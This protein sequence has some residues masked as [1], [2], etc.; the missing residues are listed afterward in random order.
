MQT[1]APC[2][3]QQIGA[4]LTREMDVPM[5]NQSYR[6]CQPWQ[7][8][9]GYSA[10][11]PPIHLN[12]SPIVVHSA[13]VAPTYCPIRGVPTVPAPLSLDPSQ[14]LSAPPPP[15]SGSGFEWQQHWGAPPLAPPPPCPSLS[16]LPPI[17]NGVVEP[18]ES[19]PDQSGHND[20]RL[21]LGG[22][23]T[24]QDCSVQ[25]PGSRYGLD[26][27]LIPS[28]VTVIE[29]DRAQWEGRVFVSDSSG[30][31]PPL[32]STECTVEDVGSASPRFIRCTS[33]SFPSEGGAAQR[34]HLPLGAIITPLAQPGAG[35]RPLVQVSRSEEGACVLCCGGCA[36]QMCPSFTWQDCGQ[37]FHCPF[38]GHVTEVPW[39]CYQPT[40]RGRTRRVDAEQ[41]AE[42]SHGSY[43]ILETQGQ[44]CPA[45]LLAVDV[46]SQAVRGGQLTHICQQLRSFLD[47]LQRDSGSDQSQLRVGVVTYHS[48]LHLYNLNPALSRPHML[49]ITQTEELELP[50]WEGLLVPLRDC[51][52]AIDKVLQ[53][54]PSLFSEAEDSPAS[55]ELPVH[56]GLHILKVAG[57]PGKVLFFH[58]A[59]P[60]D[61]S[62]NCSSG[63]SG[64]FSSSKEKSLFQPPEHCV[65]LA[66]E[67]VAQGCSFHL[68]LF[69][70]QAVGGAWPGHTP[71][72]TGGGV[73]SYGCLQG[74]VDSE[75]FHSDLRRCVDTET[76][77]RVEM[78]VSVSKGL[79]VSGCFGAFTPGPD[80]AHIRLATIDWHTALAVQFTHHSPLD[81]ERG[82]VIQVALS[83]TSSLGERRT[84][85]H[86]LSLRCSRHLVD[87]FRNCQAETL[88]TFY[89]KRVYCAVLTRPLQDLRD[90]LLT[91]LTAM[92]TCYRQHCSTTALTHGQLVL[93]QGLKSL[94]V[95]LNSLR[96]SEVLLPGL[97]GSVPLRLQLRSQ[98]V[99]MD[100]AS[101]AAHF[102]PQ[103]L[104]LHQCEEAV[105]A[106]RCSRLSL[107]EEGVYLAHDALGLVLW[108]GHHAP[109]SFL[110]CLFNTPSFP[111]L[112]SGECCLPVL[113]NAVSQ[114]VRGLIDTL[115]RR[116]AHSL[117][118][119]VVKQ[120]QGSEEALQRLLVED[121]SPNGGASYPDFLYHVHVSSLKLLP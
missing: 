13:A 108:V 53:Q 35:E 68:F 59:P 34:C 57:C 3:N 11:P 33:Y 5:A 27:Q 74:Q 49:V 40:A 117:R 67:C 109:P 24:K 38:C 97:R 110:S 12:N 118:L 42:L 84:R 64:F 21:P 31:L 114:R 85:V 96:R 79:R 20:T 47:S 115:R 102:Y 76:G 2:W 70:Q 1:R 62:L 61:G 8:P 113:D 6:S 81:E 91:E 25:S 51:R 30:Q 65:A 119:Q 95:M 26:P 43:E 78:Q 60:S 86:S 58:T 71:Y 75:Q 52:T 41:R 14:H 93:P 104:P 29:E 39:Q 63:S 19:S 32:S 37:R 17:A 23:S 107:E 106:V 28:A 99:T 72:L 16:T 66:Q 90:E 98:L 4:H 45:L 120:G 15:S 101:T 88:L 105:C 18:W 69:S 77:Y 80:P 54:I 94:P 7:H 116:S 89:C 22:G 121:K 87:T 82:V 44:Q 50:V 103:L 55:Q 112:P 36:A 100:T 56:Y 46:S 10:R 48:S 9:Q 92:L 111:V 83:Y 73:Y